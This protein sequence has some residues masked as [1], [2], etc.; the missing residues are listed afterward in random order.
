MDDSILTLLADA[1]VY[2]VLIYL[3]V[4]ESNKNQQLLSAMLERESC[5]ARDMLE[6]ALYGRM[7]KNPDDIPEHLN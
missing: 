1:P 4:K 3:L 6:L 5:H 7:R 2:F